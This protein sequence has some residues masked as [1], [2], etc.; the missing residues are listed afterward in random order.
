MVSILIPFADFF[1]SGRQLPVSFGKSE[2]K[3]IIKRNAYDLVS[4]FIN[5]FL[6]RLW[7]ARIRRSEFLNV[8]TI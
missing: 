7:I 2:T 5:G 1:G 8:E 4:W 3:V 6:V